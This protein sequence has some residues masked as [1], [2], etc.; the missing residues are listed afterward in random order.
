MASNKLMLKNF[1]IQAFAGISKNNP[2]VISFPEGHRFLKAQGDQGTNKTSTIEALKALLGENMVANAINKEDNDKR[3]AARFIG[4]DGLLY[5]VKITK[6]TFVLENIVTDAEGNPVLDEKGKE[7]TREEKKPMS[8]IRTLIGPLGISPMKLK[9]KKAA[10]QIE[11]IESFYGASAEENKI[12]EA[13]IKKKISDAYKKRTDVNRDCKKVDA[14]LEKNDYY[15]RKQFWEGEFV[16]LEREKEVL[17]SI[18][19]KKKV[20]ED[21]IRAEEGLV[22]INKGIFEAETEVTA[23]EAEIKR[24]TKAV[25]EKKIKITNLENRKKAGELYIEENKLVKEEQKRLTDDLATIQALKSDKV[26]YDFMIEQEKEREKLLKEKKNLTDTYESASNELAEF[27]KGITPDI[28]DF[29]VCVAT[30]EN[31]REGLFYKNMSVSE[32][33]ESELWEMCLL[34]WAAFD[35]RVVFLENVSNLG[36]NAVER[37][38]WFTENGGY[39][40]ASEMD[41]AE[42]NIKITINTKIN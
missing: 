40:F 31:P 21:Y 23:M 27:I 1:N 26:S 13:E 12:K 32:M 37:L 20:S 36:S 39:I 33:C 28:K 7:R 29:E 2:I 4:K 19:N 8:L 35:V 34:I 24:L 16:K 11:W 6:T 30:E 3:A 5:Q 38:N 41:R 22:T 17:D 14:V 18:E 9:E 15:L 42:K 10:E 25:E